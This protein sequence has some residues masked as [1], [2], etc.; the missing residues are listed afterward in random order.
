KLEPDYYLRGKWETQVSQVCARC[1]E[2][3]T[4]PLRQAFELGLAH[5][6]HRKAHDP[7]LAEESEELDVI[8]FEG[9]ELDLRPVIE[10]QFFLS[11]PYQAVCQENCLGICQRCGKNRNVEPCTCAAAPDHN[12]FS[13]LQQMKKP[14]KQ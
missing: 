14:L 11:I 8:Y 1:A 4:L 10:E 7:D 6:S 13:G 9:P 2:A 5:I 3:F 12:P